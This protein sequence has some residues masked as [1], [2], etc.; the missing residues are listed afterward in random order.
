MTRT[1]LR[2][3][4]P[5]PGPSPRRESGLRI[6]LRSRDGR[7]AAGD[8]RGAD[9]I[10]GATRAP[11]AATRGFDVLEPEPLRRPRGAPARRLFGRPRARS[12]AV[13]VVSRWRL[14]RRRVARTLRESPSRWRRDSSLSTST[15]R[16]P[17]PV[18][19]DSGFNLGEFRTAVRFRLGERPGFGGRSDPHRPL[20][21]LR[22]RPSRRPGR[23]RG[24]GEP[25]EGSAAS[26]RGD[27]VR[28]P[29][30]QPESPAK[31][32]APAQAD[33][34]IPGLQACP[35]RAR[36][37]SPVRRVSP[38]DPP[39][40]IVNSTN[41]IV[42]QIH[43]RWM[44]RRLKAARVAYRLLMI[45][46]SLH[47]PDYEGSNAAPW[48]PASCAGTSISCLTQP[49]GPCPASGPEFPP[50]PAT[51]MTGDTET[52]RPTQRAP[53]TETMIASRSDST[54]PR[55]PLRRPSIEAA[56]LP[57]GPDGRTGA[58]RP[59]AAAV[60]PS[61]LAPPP[62]PARSTPRHPGGRGPWPSFS[63]S[64]RT[65]RCLFRGRHHGVDVFFCSRDS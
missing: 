12:T 19:R 34:P 11:A 17:A 31:V 25:C 48:I 40:L 38:D 51:V 14:D 1:G 58:R 52:P 56:S 36:D 39:T 32:P 8:P 2:L 30:A 3:L 45:P 4:S 23:D 41:Q 16:S 42:P 6:R 18:R 65:P 63:W 22:R 33:R 10:D 59:S 62:K 26:R 35:R 20:G 54:S 64:W 47:S 50:Y 5:Y 57:D 55:R 46:G 13:V 15:T 43:A 53:L 49:Q 61:P 9:R 21:K 60:R 29:G 24:Q 7:S 37:A 27:L 28:A 44:A